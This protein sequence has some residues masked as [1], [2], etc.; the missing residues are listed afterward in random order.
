MSI[1]RS[2]SYKLP[3]KTTEDQDGGATTSCKHGCG[4]ET[5]VGAG[6]AEVL[7][8]PIVIFTVKEEQRTAMKA[9]LGEQHVSALLPTGFRKS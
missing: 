6:V 8:E 4:K 1:A 9:F 5:G 2:N 7:S 3:L